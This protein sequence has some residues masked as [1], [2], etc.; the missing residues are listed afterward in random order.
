MPRPIDPSRRDE[1]LDRVIGYVAEHGLTGLTL[2]KLAAALGFSTNVISY[3]FGSKH[4]LIEAALMR[5]RAEQRAV[6]E[7][8]L[9]ENPRA[10]AA[11]GVMTIWYWWLEDP[12]HLAYSRMSIEAFMDSKLPTPEIRSSLLP[13]WVDYFTRWLERD[14]HQRDVAEELATLLLAAQTGLITDVISGGDR[15]RIT[16]AMYRIA[17]I[18]EPVHSAD[19]Q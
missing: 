8:L 15:E 1:V 12:A 4:G 16:R 13:Y 19:E 11:Q 9:A 6:Y 10:T 2:R 18:L 5:A 7:R 17:R 3:Q 14:G